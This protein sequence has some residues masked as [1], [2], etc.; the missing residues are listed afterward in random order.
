[1]L[2]ASKEVLGVK[3]T[4]YIGEY[5]GFQM[6][7]FHSLVRGAVELHLHTADGIT[8]QI[9][10][11]E[12]AT[13]NLTR[14]DNALAKIPE[15][16][17][18]AKERFA[19]LH[20]ELEDAKVEIDKPFPRAK[21]LEEKIA[22]LAELNISLNMDRGQE[23][24]S[25][26]LANA[27]EIMEAAEATKR[28]FDG[29]FPTT[30]EAEKWRKAYNDLHNEGGNG[31]VPT[32]VTDEQVAWAERTLAGERVAEEE[33]EDLPVSK[34]AA[35]RIEKDFLES[36]VVI[37]G[38]PQNNSPELKKD[39]VD[40][41][42]KPEIGQDIIYR[43]E[44]GGKDWKGKVLSTDENTVTIHATTETGGKRITLFKDKGKFELAHPPVS[45]EI[46]IK[47]VIP[48]R[49]EVNTVAYER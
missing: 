32:I 18:S 5:K 19:E 33:G 25:P 41:S 37:G 12:S 20:K 44:I 21:E 2:E 35:L 26:D 10:L 8:H 49:R 23:E 39:R 40:H 36:H 34:A 4:A 16:L 38:I 14:I 7:A 43:P 3:K 11:G 28:Y 30:E 1:M 9:E 45:Q 46:A 27:E 42:F 48:I 22:R 13:G 24:S 6:M 29:K 17:D 15:R 47:N 31:Y